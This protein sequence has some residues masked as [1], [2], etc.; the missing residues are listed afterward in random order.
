MSESSIRSREEDE[1]LHRS[2]KKVK[3]NLCGGSPRQA[4][5]LNSDGGEQSYRE[6]LGGVT[7][8]VFEHACNFENVMEVDDAR[9]VSQ[10]WLSR[11]ELFSD[12]LILKIRNRA[13]VHRCGA[14]HR[15]SDA[16][17]RKNQQR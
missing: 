2:T 9:I 4:F 16:K 12:I 6:K 5:N 15:A 1:E 3:E 17:V 13:M 8:G 7:L 10:M 11:M 14:C